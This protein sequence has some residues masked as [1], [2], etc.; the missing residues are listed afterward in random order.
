MASLGFWAR[1]KLFQLLLTF[2]ETLCFKNRK[3]VLAFWPGKLEHFMHKK[4]N[5]LIK[6]THLP[7]FGLYPFGRQ[8]YLSPSHLAPPCRMGTA[9]TT[10]LYTSS[11]VLRA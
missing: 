3:Y 4:S 10:S 5:T 9:T 7:S 8:Q 2:L 1:G 11:A 6:N